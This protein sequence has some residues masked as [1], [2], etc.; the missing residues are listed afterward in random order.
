MCLWVFLKLFLG[1]GRSVKPLICQRSDVRHW[2]LEG[3]VSV[4]ESRLVLRLWFW[5]WLAAA[6]SCSFWVSSPTSFWAFL[7]VLS[8]S[9]LTY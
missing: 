1:G 3:F 5:W 6:P 4:S 8:G 7:A 2:E 9:H